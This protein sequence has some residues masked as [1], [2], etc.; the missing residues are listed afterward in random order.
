[1]ADQNDINAYI[2][3]D[4]A[5]ET[6][7]KLGRTTE[8]DTLSNI[9]REVQE[10]IPNII[11][12]AAAGKVGPVRTESTDRKKDYE[13]YMRAAMQALDG[14]EILDSFIKKIRDER[15]EKLQGGH[16]RKSKKANRRN[17]RRSYRY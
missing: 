2:F 4:F 14:S 12:L 16:R 8:V 15:L 1:M 7:R 5:Q 11:S 10:K 13:V 17:K 3:L 9:L 6:A